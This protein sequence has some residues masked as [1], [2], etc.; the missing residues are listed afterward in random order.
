[1]DAFCFQCYRTVHERRERETEKETL[2]NG[3][4]YIALS[5][6]IA[7]FRN[8]YVKTTVCLSLKNICTREKS[9]IL[10]SD[11]QIKNELN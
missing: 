4:D 10:K 1:M 2:E 9:I 6:C 7:N 8:F 3:R 11:R 5:H